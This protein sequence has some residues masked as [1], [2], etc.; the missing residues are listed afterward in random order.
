MIH[1][2]SKMWLANKYALNLAN[3]TDSMSSDKL[4][5]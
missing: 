2:T 5:I 3:F 1:I 4:G